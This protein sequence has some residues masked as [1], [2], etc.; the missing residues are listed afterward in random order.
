MQRRAATEGKLPIGG[1]VRY[2]EVEGWVWVREM[3]LRVLWCG[4]LYIDL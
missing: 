4:R 1:E 3:A 2:A